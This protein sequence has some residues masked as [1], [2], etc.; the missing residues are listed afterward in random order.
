MNIRA[1]S[2]GYQPPLTIV[3]TQSRRWPGSAISNALFDNDD[4]LDREV[5]TLQRLI[6]LSS[7]A[8]LT[9]VSVVP[10]LKVSKTE[11]NTWNRRPIADSARLRAA[12]N[13]Q[14]SMRMMATPKTV[15]KSDE[16]Y[17]SVD[18][19]WSRLR[20]GNTSAI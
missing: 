1:H 5:E 13:I 14:R 10:A 16:G 2:L 19:R 8:D 6:A 15:E 3:G 17:K 11:G 7:Q 9:G 12:T 20:L 4:L 18:E